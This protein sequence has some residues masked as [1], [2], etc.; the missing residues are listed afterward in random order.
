[1]KAYCTLLALF[2]STVIHAQDVKLSIKSYYQNGFEALEKD[3]AKG[4]RNKIAFYIRQLFLIVTIKLIIAL[5]K[6]I[7]ISI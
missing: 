2:F 4:I 5:N 3:I 6:S 7:H 1:M